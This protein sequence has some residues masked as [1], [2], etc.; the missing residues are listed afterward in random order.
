MKIARTKRKA[1]YI[2]CI[3]CALLILSVMTRILYVNASTKHGSNTFNGVHF[4]HTEQPYPAKRILPLIWEYKCGTIISYKENDVEFEIDSVDT[5]AGVSN[6][7]IKYE[8]DG[9]TC[10][11]FFNLEKR[12]MRC[13]ISKDRTPSKIIEYGKNGF[14]EADKAYIDKFK[15]KEIYDLL[16]GMNYN[17]PKGNLIG[18][19]LTDNYREWNHL[20]IS[21]SD[22]KDTYAEHIEI[23]NALRKIDEIV[24]H[25]N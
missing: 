9:F 23:L 25:K 5:A 14:D 21:K 15:L 12:F 3:A 17:F 8:L 24:K 4:Y 16:S 10:S 1:V 6:S 19:W 13:V 20:T 22:L 18:I 2:V 11:S 7:C